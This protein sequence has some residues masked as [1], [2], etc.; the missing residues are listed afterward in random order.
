MTQ[1]GLGRR[2]AL[3]AAMFPVAAMALLNGFYKQALVDQ[4]LAWYWAADVAQF[5][6]APLAC[7]WL[8]L[9]PAGVGAA[10]LGLALKPDRFGAGGIGAG[11]IAFTAA[12]LVAAT[13]PVFVYTRITLWQYGDVSALDAA[14]PA[15]GLSRLLVALYMAVSA[16][17]VE[18]VVFRALPW[19]Y[20]QQA[21]GPRWG[22]TL[23]LWFGPLLF[24]LCHAE[25]GPGGMIAAWWFGLVAARFYLKL[26]S[27]WPAV[28]AHFAVDLLMFGPW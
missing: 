4:G 23:Y 22:R 14:M 26:R 10:E 8:L 20:L 25:Q 6:L 9:R 16:A 27:L 2:E 3:L 19:L 5:V 12:L 24:A 21:V 1:A 15:A 28:L 17:L 7:A 18:E 11:T 13:W